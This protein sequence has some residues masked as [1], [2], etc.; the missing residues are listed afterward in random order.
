VITWGGPRGAQTQTLTPFTRRQG[1]PSSVVILTLREAV[2]AW[3]RSQS[4]VT[5]IVG[6]R[7]YFAQPSQR[8]AYPC[9]VIKVPTRKYGHNLGGADGTSVATVAITALAIAESQ[10]IALAE[11]IRNFAD[12]FRGTQSG[13]GILSCLIDDEADDETAPPDGS[14]NWIYQVT[15]EYRVAH[16][17]PAPTSVTQSSA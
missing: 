17:V 2:A 9:C 4:S 12:G 16:R 13:V 8:A 1:L 10:V 5:A 11:A 15:L 7:I 14:D 3:L 6:N